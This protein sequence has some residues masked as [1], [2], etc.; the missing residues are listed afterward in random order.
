MQLHNNHSN[1]S[2]YTEDDSCTLAGR[3]FD[4]NR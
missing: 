4:G 3:A 2:H 1:T